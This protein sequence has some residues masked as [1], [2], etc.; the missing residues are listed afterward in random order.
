LSRILLDTTVASLFLPGTRPRPERP[1]YEPHLVRHTLALSFQSVAEFW[2][3]AEKRN[4]SAR[5]RQALEGFLRKFLIIP[6][7]HELARVWG[8]VS[9]EAERQG[10]RLEAGDAWIAAT[11]VDRSLPLYTHDRDFLD[12]DLPGL[13]VV[14]FVDG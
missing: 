5:R 6:Y 1:L 7:H 9:A 10:R 4:W 3:L 2:K 12:R 14:S 13:T 8:R 11:A